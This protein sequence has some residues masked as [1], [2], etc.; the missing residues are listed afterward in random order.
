MPRPAASPSSNWNSSYRKVSCQRPGGGGR[1]SDCDHEVI[2]PNNQCLYLRC[3]STPTH[4]D[5][6]PIPLTGIASTFCGPRPSI[7]ATAARSPVMPTL[8]TGSSIISP[9]TDYVWENLLLA[10]ADYKM[11]DDFFIL[12]ELFERSEN[13]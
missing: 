7:V 13:S 3:R 1:L 9:L 12:P 5:I 6:T 10:S 4:K 8:A 2:L 11:A